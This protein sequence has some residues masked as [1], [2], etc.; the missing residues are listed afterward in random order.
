MRTTL[1]DIANYLNVSVTTVS[2]AINDKGDI[3]PAM[4]EKVLQVAKILDYKPNSIAISLRKKTASDLIGV[5]IP[6]VNHYFFST[7]LSGITTSEFER[8]DY[9]IMIGESNHDVTREKELINKF[10]DHYVAGII[11]V[12]TRQASSIENVTALQRS[13]TPFIL[14]DRSFDAYDSSSIQYDDYQ[15]GYLAASHLISKGRKKIALLKGDDDCSISSYR[16]RGYR[17]AL[18]EANLPVYDHLIR[19]CTNASRSEGYQATDELLSHQTPPDGIMTITDQLAAGSLKCAI[20][21]NIQVP[22]DLSIIGY[23]DSEISKTIT[24]KLSTINQDGYEMGKLA[25]EYII[26]MCLHKE[27]V[28]QKVFTPELIIREST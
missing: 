24:P 6:T 2:R 12:P 5:I 28:R 20:N 9:M 21:R 15:G 27:V 18:H 10:Q 14:I 3:S 1:K 4:R 16:E 17:S 8:D 7:I 23:S 26:Q 11:L 19:T 25:R 22:R 13:S